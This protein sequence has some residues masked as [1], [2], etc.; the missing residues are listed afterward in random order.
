MVTRTRQPVPAE[1]AAAILGRRRVSFTYAR[2]ART[3]G[4]RVVS[5]HA[6]YRTLTGKVCVQGIQVAG[7][8]SH[9]GASL[10]GW[11]TFELRMMSGVRELPDAFEVAAEFRPDSPVYR[12]MII[13]CLRGWARAG[14]PKG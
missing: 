1:L 5:P 14:Q 9:G 4:P 3:A 7:P 10:P 12:R 6:V 2:D 13:D 8:T 11:R